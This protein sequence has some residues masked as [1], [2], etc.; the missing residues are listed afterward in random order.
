MVKNYPVRVGREFIQ[1]IND[2]KIEHFRRTGR[3]PSSRIITN[4]IA[5]IINN[6]DVLYD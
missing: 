1:I 5:K 4:K 2:I 6:G 3:M